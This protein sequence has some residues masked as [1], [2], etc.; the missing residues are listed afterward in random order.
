MW[1]KR[2]FPSM[3]SKKA[4]FRGQVRCDNFGHPCFSAYLSLDEARL[5]LNPPEEQTG[6]Q[7]NRKTEERRLDL[8]VVGKQKILF[9]NLHI[10][11]SKK[12]HRIFSTS[13][14]SGNRM[15]R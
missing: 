11:S 7:K 12:S 10:E 2:S 15:M 9:K 3:R 13:L 4:P 8:E 14:P 6:K 5:Y 1:V